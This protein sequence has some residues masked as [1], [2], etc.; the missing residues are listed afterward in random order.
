MYYVYE[1]FKVES[2]E[3]FYVGKGTGRR[4]KE[5][6]NRNPYFL[7]VYRKYKC[8]VRKVHEGLTDE[9]AFEKERELILHYRKS[10]QAYCNLTDG[11]VGFSTGKLNPTYKRSHRGMNNYFYGRKH[12]E[13]TKRL[14]SEHRKGKGGQFGTDN[15]MYGVQRFGEDNPMFGRTGELH[16]NAKMI[17]VEYLDGTTERLTAKQCE[18]K[19]GIAFTRIRDTGG[20]LH[21]KKKSKNDIYEGTRIILSQPVT[22]SREA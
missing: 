8:D 5:L 21:Y 18:K 15:P 22:T 10:G 7:A 13:E 6:H 9:Q 17:D 4:Y 12:T 3:V 11:G 1:Y 16:H 20:V 14:I 19:F 2:N